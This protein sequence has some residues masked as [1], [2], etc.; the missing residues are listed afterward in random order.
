[1]KYCA[2]L[3][4]VSKYLCY[5]LHMINSKTVSLEFRGVWP[6]FSFRGRAVTLWNVE[7][8]FANLV[9][10]TSVTNITL[11]MVGVLIPDGSYQ[12]GHT[13]NFRLIPH[14]E[15]SFLILPDEFTSVK[16]S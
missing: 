1:M 16:S 9:V 13:Y 7:K 11:R 4:Q 12:I 10:G 6:K 2:S 5:G 15:S 8:S 3:N 14:D